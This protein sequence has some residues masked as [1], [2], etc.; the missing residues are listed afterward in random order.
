MNMKKTLEIT[1]DYLVF[2]TPTIAQFRLEPHS[3][4]SQRARCCTFILERLSS[5]KLLYFLK[6]LKSYQK[7]VDEN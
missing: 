6:K 3:S 4:Y 5:F 2:R 7:I 1:R